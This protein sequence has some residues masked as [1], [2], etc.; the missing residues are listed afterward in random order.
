MLTRRMTDSPRRGAAKFDA[1]ADDYTRLHANNV[2]V[3]G[4]EPDYFAYYKVDCLARKGVQPSDRILDYGCGIGNVTSKLA[5]RFQ[6]LAGYEPSVASAEKA[7]ERV[8]GAAIHHDLDALPDAAFDVAMLSCVLHHVQPP[9]RPAMLERLRSKL[10][11][12]GRLFVFEHNPFNPVTRYAVSTCEFDDDAVLLW[13]WQAKRLLQDTGFERVELDYIVFFPKPLAFLR[14]L[15]PK[16]RWL[17]A[18]AQQ[19]IVATKP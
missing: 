15:E 8:P 12:G 6:N 10:R 5:E 9:E 11:P 16:L 19:L 4:E 1:Y 7:Q 18:G 17:P 14:G 13:P 3:S 2:A